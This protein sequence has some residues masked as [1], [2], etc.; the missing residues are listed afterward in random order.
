[1][2]G[3]IKDG[4]KI[5]VWNLYKEDGSLAGHLQTIYEKPVQPEP[6]KPVVVK[7]DTVEEKTEFVN[8]YRRKSRFR[9]SYFEGKKNEYRSFALGVNPL[10]LILGS[11]PMY[12]EYYLQERMGLEINPI[13]YRDPLFTNEANLPYNQSFKKGYAISFKNKFYNRNKDL[14]GLIYFGYE[15]RYTSNT[16]L[17][18]VLENA[19]PRQISSNEEVYDF[20]IIF[21]DRLLQDYARKGWT[22][23]LF[24]GIGVGYR[25]YRKNYEENSDY[26]RVFEGIRKQ[27]LNIPIRIGFSAGYLF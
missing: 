23:D 19:M 15:L 5:G 13:L 7:K 27:P 16:Y 3:I 14:M 18:N 1:M 12:L 10:A 4:E 17:A 6:I 20:A 26:D 24:M 21:G 11:F 2:E 9:I 22:L 25:S 8:P